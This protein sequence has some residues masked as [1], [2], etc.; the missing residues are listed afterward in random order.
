MKRIK[1]IICSIKFRYI[2][3]S[4]I[5]LMCA[6]SI[7]FID[8]NFWNTLLNSVKTTLESTKPTEEL[9]DDTG[10]V[11]YI[12]VLFDKNNC[13]VSAQPFDYELCFKNYNNFINNDGCITIVGASGIL[14]AP[15]SGKVRICA[16]TDGVAEIKI[17]HTSQF[18]SVFAGQIGLGVK[19]DVFVQKGQPLAI[20]FGDLQFFVSQNGEILDSLDFSNGEILWKE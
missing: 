17:E 9:F 4:L 15:A 7:S 3:I 19:D 13:L 14:Y 6:M 5:V 10:K 20:L 16:L 2:L 8:R 1:N 18:V 12:S 11:K